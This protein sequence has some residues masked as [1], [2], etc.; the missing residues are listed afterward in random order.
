MPKKPLLDRIRGLTLAQCDQ[1]I[2][3]GAP[4]VNQV[5]LTR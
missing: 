2:G 1:R 4:S 3:I 5:T